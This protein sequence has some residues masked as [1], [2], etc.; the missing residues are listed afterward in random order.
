MKQVRFSAVPPTA[1]RTADWPPVDHSGFQRLLTLAGPA[2]R[3]ELIRRLITDL[4]S[5]EHGLA[6]GFAGPDWAELRARSHVLKALAGTL[7]AQA[8]HSA[9]ERLNR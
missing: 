6:R 4:Q 9:A 3:H 5:V 2:D 1:P 8:L 7:G